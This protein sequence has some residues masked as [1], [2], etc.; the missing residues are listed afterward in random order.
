MKIDKNTISAYGK[1]TLPQILAKQAEKIGS[2]GIAIRE[3]AYGIWQTFD[4]TEYF[5]YT[6]KVGLG[7]KSI[8]L[9]RGEN[10]GIITDNHPEWLFAELG[11]QSVGAVTLNLFTSAVSAE[12][13]HTLSRIRASYVIAGDRNRWINFSKLEINCPTSARLSMLIPQG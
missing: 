8:G 1:L 6:T 12:L 9:T 5:E 13:A 11:G 2:Q 3:K 4:W 7:L 10:I